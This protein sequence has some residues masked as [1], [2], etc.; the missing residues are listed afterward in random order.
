M[1]YLRFKTII[2]KIN[3]RW[4]KL[5]L[6]P[7][8]VFCFHQTSE[9]YDAL[10]MWE[11]DW[12]QIDQLKSNLQKLKKQYTF[13]S[14]SEAKYHFQ[15]DWFRRKRYA[16]LTADDGYKSILNILPWLQEQQI[17]L[18]W[19]INTHYLDGQ[20][21][22]EINEEQARGALGDNVS[23]ERL[24]SAMKGMYIS[25]EELFNLNSPLIE[26]G[27]HGH[28][29]L[30]AIQQ[31]EEDFKLNVENCKKVLQSHP[32]YVPFFAYTW[33]HYNKQTDRILKEMNL[34]PVL[35]NGGKNYNNANC[36]DRECID[37]KN[38]DNNV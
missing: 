14:L 1:N 5:R 18:T 15:H 16:V 20:S 28:K 32:R 22:S 30:D 10:R 26:I 12:T 38:Y 17:S 4:K 37:G 33:G 11:C 9:E 7:I 2:H 8:R 34:T 13:I 23:D 3:N 6:Q 25:K 35:V 36:I 31:S 24:S 21:W 29:H 19:F 27:L